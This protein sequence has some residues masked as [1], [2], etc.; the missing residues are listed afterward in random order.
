MRKCAE[1]YLLTIPSSD[2][3]DK[4]FTTGTK[5]EF[6]LNQTLVFS[7]IEERF[8]TRLDNG[9]LGNWREGAELN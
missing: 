5:L 3:T 1:C 8:P 6:K 2:V 7:S 4:G 9:Y